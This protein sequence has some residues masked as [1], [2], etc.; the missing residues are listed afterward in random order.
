MRGAY[1]RLFRGAPG[2]AHAHRARENFS[3]KI[4]RRRIVPRAVGHLVNE[5]FTRYC[6]LSMPNNLSLIIRHHISV[7]VIR[8][9][10]EMTMNGMRFPSSNRTRA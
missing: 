9:K 7:P 3:R 10:K 6:A 4:F 5:N 2:S 1:R 8:S